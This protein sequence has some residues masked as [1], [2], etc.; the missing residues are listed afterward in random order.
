MTDLRI[1]RQTAVHHDCWRSGSCPVPVIEFQ[2]LKFSLFEGNI[3]RQIADAAFQSD[4]EAYLHDNESPISGRT[5]IFPM[6]QISRARSSPRESAL[7][8]R[9]SHDTGR[10]DASAWYPNTWPTRDL[11]SRQ[12]TNSDGVF[13]PKPKV[14]SSHN[15]PQ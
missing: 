5:R 7:G 8:F 1:P 15:M 4:L 3:F 13:D 12:K 2:Q 6:R 14:N 10:D 11:A 9:R